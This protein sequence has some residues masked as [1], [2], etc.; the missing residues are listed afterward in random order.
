MI[1]RACRGRLTSISAIL[2]I[3][4]AILAILLV[5]TGVIAGWSDYPADLAKWISTQ[6]PQVLDERWVAANHD[7]KNEWVV[8]LL[9]GRPSVRL[10][11]VKREKGSYYPEMQESY[12][13]MPFKVPRGSAKD[14]LAGE[15]FSLQV[16]DGWI[17]GFNAGEFGAGLW[18]FSP[19]GKRREKIS[20]D[21]VVGFFAT[22]AGLLALEGIAHGGPSRGRIIRL[23]TGEDG[24]WRSEPFVDLKGRP[25]DGGK[26]CRR[27]F[28]GGD[29]QSPAP[30]SSRHQKDRRAPG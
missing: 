19:D 13:V 21:R 10:R 17:I 14:G 29:E 7:T 2:K 6:P 15:W 22:D 26:D 11:A 1:E 9:E 16:A 30:R 5:A 4:R 24:R 20:E 23:A 8:F 27:D 18:W 25:G 12:P 3:A 28:A